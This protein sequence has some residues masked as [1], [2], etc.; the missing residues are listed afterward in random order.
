MFGLPVIRPRDALR[1]P[2]V[3]TYLKAAFHFM[4]IFY[5]PDFDRTLFVRITN[6]YQ[7]I[8]NAG[9]SFCVDFHMIFI[10]AEI[11]TKKKHQH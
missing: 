8:L 5:L 3:W 1:T 2:S 11:R 9:V 6:S 7:T 4:R 10:S